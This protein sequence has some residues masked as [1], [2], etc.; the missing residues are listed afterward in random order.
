MKVSNKKH[1]IIY[2]IC[3][4][5]T[6]VVLSCFF[7]FKN[8]NQKLDSV[9]LKNIIKILVIKKLYIDKLRKMIYNNTIN[10]INV[11]NYH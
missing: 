8:N 10:Y 2:A 4:A 9:K 7:M 11:Q 6:I 1:M 3:A 5:I